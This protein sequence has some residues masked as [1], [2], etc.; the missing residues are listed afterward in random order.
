MAID[1]IEI[2]ISSWI[3]VLEGKL[4]ELDQRAG[5]GGVVVDKS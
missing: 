4:T 2:K 1:Y 5:G 3:F